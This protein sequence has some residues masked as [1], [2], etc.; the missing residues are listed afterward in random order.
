MIVS[1]SAGNPF[2]CPIGLDHFP[3]LLA[4]QSAGDGSWQLFSNRAFVTTRSETF[5]M[6]D[7]KSGSIP[8]TTS[9]FSDGAESAKAVTT[10]SYREDDL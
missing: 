6:P 3:T 10:L 1:L 7:A 8:G 4:S 2:I 5:R 9:G